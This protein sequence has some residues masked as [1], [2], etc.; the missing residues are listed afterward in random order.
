MALK[1]TINFGSAAF[2]RFFISRVAS[3]VAAGWAGEG[4]TEYRGVDESTQFPVFCVT[5]IGP[6]IRENQP[7]TSQP[8]TPIIKVPAVLLSRPVP[9]F[10]SRKVPR[11]RPPLA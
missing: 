7:A 11:L 3:V 8:L 9:P 2:A 10:L 5:S 1:H 6:L 4:C